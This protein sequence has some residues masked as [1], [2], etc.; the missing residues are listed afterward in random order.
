MKN[1]T[2]WLTVFVIGFGLCLMGTGCSKYGKKGKKGKGGY[3][4]DLVTAEDQLNID[5][6]P[7]GEIRFG[8]VGDFSVGQ[9]PAVYFEYDSS[10][11]GADEYMKIE[12]AAAVLNEN[13]DARMI[14]EGHC[15]ERG[16]REYNLALGERRALAVRSYLSN[17]G[18]EGDRVQTRS[19]GEESPMAMGHDDASWAQNRRGE[20]LISY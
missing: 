13:L 7:L 15:D 11:I 9:F 6:G 18:I 1:H 17:L 2:R 8:D 20:F 16:S 19:M 4:G 3:P 12:A 10:S 14:V 5:G